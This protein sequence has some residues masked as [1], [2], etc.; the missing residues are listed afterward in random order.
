MNVQEEIKKSQNY[1]KRMMTET[2]IRKII[3]GEIAFLECDDNYAHFDTTA[4]LD[5]VQISQLGV[6]GIAY[7]NLTD[8]RFRTITVRWS[9][10]SGNPTEYAKRKYALDNKDLGYIYPY[11]TVTSYTDSNGAFAY[12]Y[13]ISTEFLIR[14][15]EKNENNL[16]KINGPGG[17]KFVA[18]P[19]ELIKGN[20]FG[21]EWKLDINDNRH[22]WF[23]MEES[24]RF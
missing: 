24:L 22:K 5:N 2:H 14:F 20:C 3:G 11:W 8:T 17:V 9:I 4:G 6:R 23:Y 15:I 7:R 1:F 10:P 13:V 16:S 19:Y 21:L 18:V 12:Y